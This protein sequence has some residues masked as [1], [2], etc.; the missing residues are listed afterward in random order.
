MV[1][2]EAEGSEAALTARQREWLRHLRACERS[3]DTVKDYASRRGLSVQSLYQAGKR[4][5]RRGVLASRPQRRAIARSFVKVAMPMRPVEAGAAAVWRIRL[6]G[7]VVFE[8]SAPF[9]SE[10]LVSLLERLGR[11]R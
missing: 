6:P 8:S 10:G 2:R 7:G 1:K 3:G 4:L 9:E 11:L 5:R